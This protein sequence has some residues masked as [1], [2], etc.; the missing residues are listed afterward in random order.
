MAAMPERTMIVLTPDPLNATEALRFVSDAASGATCLFEG[1]VR[2]SS[3]EGDVTGLRYEA[4][5]ELAT[6]R[7]REIA[8][9]MLEKWPVRR[10]AL[11]HRTGDLGVG[12][13]SVI[14][15]CSTPHRAEAFEAC[16]HGIERIKEEVPIWKR[17][18]L[19]TGEAHWVRGS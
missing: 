17:E 6:S 12:Q 4:Y 11:L 10:A 1:T 15:A 7:M 5:E 3:S 18:Q 19:A 9:E 16:R 8:G 13:V 2:G 14:V